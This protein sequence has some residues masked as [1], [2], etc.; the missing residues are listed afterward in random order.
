M[1]SRPVSVSFQSAAS[2]AL[3][4]RITEEVLRS[5]ASTLK[6]CIKKVLLTV[7]DAREDGVSV[8]VSGLDEVDI[9]DFGTELNDAMKL[10]QVGISSI[11]LKR[12][13]FQR[14]AVKYLSD[15][16]QETKDQIAREIDEQL[17]S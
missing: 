13:I 16:R 2:K 7:S 1:A 4:F 15:A 14:L 11:T 3:D 8:A 17:R 6:E 9:G 5:Y 12:Q 10:L